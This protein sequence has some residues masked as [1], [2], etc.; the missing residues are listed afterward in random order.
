MTD[1]INTSQR[2]L[3]LVSND[4]GIAAPG[5]R[6]LI[7]CL[8]PMA[9][10]V[11]V[12]PL[13][14]QSGMSMAVTVRNPLRI[15][16]MED[17]RGVAMYAVDGTPVDCVK[18]ARHR[19]LPRKPQLVVSGINHGSNAGVNLLYSGTMGAALE[20]CVLGIPSAGFS[21]TNH[22]LQADFSSCMPFIEEIC[23]QLL[24]VGLPDGV[25]L[26]VNIPDS[27]PAPQRMRVVSQCRSSWSDEYCEYTDPAGHPFYMLSGHF[28]ND[29]P[30]NENTDE[31]CM[32]HGEVSIVPVMLD[33]TAPFPAQLA[34]ED[35]T[36]SASSDFGCRWTAEQIAALRSFNSFRVKN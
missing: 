7:D 28:C 13:Y 8:L 2:P 36:Q 19:L 20:G 35:A 10:I 6:R 25:C 22:S 5:V 30:D 26:N 15:K 3:V 24:A 23:R 11:C 33:R 17:Y 1:N 4:D 32:S 31:W 16:R 14:P 18:I 12:C 34:D 9:E 21:L 27:E 29:E